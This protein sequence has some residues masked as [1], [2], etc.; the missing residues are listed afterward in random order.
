MKETGQLGKEVIF[1]ANWP[2]L[3]VVVDLRS[4]Y[5]V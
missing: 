3:P 5:M 2:S 1:S 4:E